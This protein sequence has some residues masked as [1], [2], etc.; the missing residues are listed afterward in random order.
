M[1]FL[2]VKS[3]LP[4]PHND[5]LM[6]DGVGCPLARFG[7]FHSLVG[8]DC[9]ASDLFA[10]RRGCCSWLIL[11][12]VTEDSDSI[13]ICH[14]ACTFLL[15]IEKHAIL[16]RLHLP[17]QSE[18]R[19]VLGSPG[20]RSRTATFF[21]APSG[22]AKT[23]PCPARHTCT[24]R[25][26]PWRTKDRSDKFARGRR[27]GTTRAEHIGYRKEGMTHPPRFPALTFVE[28]RFQNEGAGPILLGHFFFLV[29]AAL[30]RSQSPSS[31]VTLGPSFGGILPIGW[32]S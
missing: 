6:P 19:S 20:L 11:A 27:S 5:H 14:R 2:R 13:E 8:S 24:W 10:I 30:R 23:Q 29:R 31:C 26:S 25:A 9:K 18:V 1:Q 17:R 15:R 4:I 21:W 7:I 28:L 22:G 16:L 12:G 32:G 3:G